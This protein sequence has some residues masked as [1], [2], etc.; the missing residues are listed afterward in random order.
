LQGVRD[1]LLQF[2]QARNARQP[3]LGGNCADH[4]PEKH[5]ATTNQC[6]LIAERT[7]PLQV[8]HW[9]PPFVTNMANPHRLDEAANLIRS[10]TN[11]A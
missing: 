6:H 8:D 9:N 7:V 11:A 2:G 3:P 10:K 1:R 5:S 4:A